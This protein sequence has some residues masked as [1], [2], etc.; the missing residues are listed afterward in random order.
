MSMFA[1]G[2][3]IFSI[4]DIKRSYPDQWVAVAVTETD[5]DG[6]AS[7]GEVIMHNSDE[8]FVWT[9]VKLGEADDPI[10][11]FHTGA[12]QRVTTAA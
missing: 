7:K 3:V 2:P 10:Y 6:F 8:Q 4:M 1:N 12:R 11:V 9:A 5:A